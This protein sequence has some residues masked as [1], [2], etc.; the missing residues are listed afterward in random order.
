MWVFVR[1]TQSFDQPSFV[2]KDNLLIAIGAELDP[3]LAE[4]KSQD[5]Q[6]RS[7]SRGKANAEWLVQASAGRRLQTELSLGMLTERPFLNAG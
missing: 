1:T 5:R 7:I 6:V 3:L 4:L 2:V